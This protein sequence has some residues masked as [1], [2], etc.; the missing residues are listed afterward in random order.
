MVMADYDHG[1]SFMKTGTRVFR[2]VVIA[3]IAVIGVL[4]CVVATLRAG[5]CSRANHVREVIN[6][7]T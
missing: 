3:V 6:N 7:I 4:L 2:G 1:H 5:L